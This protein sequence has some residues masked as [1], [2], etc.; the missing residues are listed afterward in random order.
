[1]VDARELGKT[2]E[3][4]SHAARVAVSDAAGKN[5]LQ[6]TMQ[7]EKPPHTQEF[8]VGDL[9]D[10]TYTLTV[11]VDGWKEP[12]VRTF[13]RK[14]F[15]FEGN[16]LGITDQVLPPFEPVKVEGDSVGVVY[17]QY[18]LDGLG[19][20][21]SVE[22]AGNVSAGGPVEL[23]AGPVT[24]K[25][26]QGQPLAGRGKFVEVRPAAAVYE[27][28]AEHPA[29]S[30]RCRSTTE[31]DGCVKVELTLSP[32]ADRRPLESLWLEVPLRDRLMPL[33]HV[34]TT[35]LRI[36]PAGATP[37]GEGPVWDSTKFPDGNWFGNF[38][39][40]L[41]LG[42]EERGVCWFADNDAGWELATDAKGQ[43]CVACQQLIRRG[44]VLTLR[45]NLIQKPVTLAAPRKIT[46]GLMASPAKPM[47]GDWRQTGLTV[48]SPFNMGYACPATYCARRRGAAISR[49]PIGATASGPASRGRARTRSRPGNS[50]TSPP[51]WTRPS[52]KAPSTWRWARS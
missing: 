48:N 42:A 10:G 16:K 46:F 2:L 17:R 35:G 23:L 44:D 24:L 40:Y 15:P 19:L 32:G 51:T 29:V 28:T 13:T 41:W 8:S 26:D 3:A 22:A 20:W 18:R 34:S 45:V 4:T 31:M 9:P 6:G 7:W 27:G 14:H 49:S 36:N 21:R 1:M 5:I 30:V 25:V 50:G 33:W 11:G 43:P 37:E 38:K 39:C 12:L 47:R 52:A